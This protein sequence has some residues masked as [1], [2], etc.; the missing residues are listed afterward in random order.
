MGS[1]AYVFSAAVAAAAFAFVSAPMAKASAD[2]MHTTLLCVASSSVMLLVAVM[3]ANTRGLF[4]NNMEGVMEKLAPV[5]PF[6]TKHAV[7]PSTE[8]KPQALHRAAQ[9]QLHNLNTRAGVSNTNGVAPA[10]VQVPVLQQQSHVEVPSEFDMSMGAKTRDQMKTQNPASYA[11][12]KLAAVDSRTDDA[13]V[14]RKQQQAMQDRFVSSEAS[15]PPQTP[16]TGAQGRDERAEIP[17][18]VADATPGSPPPTGEEDGADDLSRAFA[19]TSAT[20]DMDD[21]KVQKLISAAG[22]TA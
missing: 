20:D 16:A 18:R 15:I 8:E 9:R 6:K 21:V 11:F 17:L 3:F 4:D 7:P 10:R 2:R 22:Q 12:N 14:D 19:A 5:N 1:R 13:R